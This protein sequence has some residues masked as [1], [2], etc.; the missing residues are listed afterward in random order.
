MARL[1]PP[2]VAVVE[3]D[4]VSRRTLGRVLQIGGFEPLLFESAEAFLSS[5]PARD[6]LCLILDVQLTGMSGIDLQHELRQ[7][8]STVP[9]IVTT[10]NRQPAIERRAEDQGCRK[11][12]WKPFSSVALLT[13][14]DAIARECSTDASVEA[15][16]PPATGGRN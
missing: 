4:T 11:V 13:L 5:P 12:L 2:L 3:D 15:G 14:L 7:A 10:G 8:G 6:L 9:V 16:R 1:A